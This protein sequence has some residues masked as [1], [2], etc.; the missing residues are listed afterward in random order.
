[1]VYLV[2]NKIFSYIECHFEINKTYCNCFLLLTSDLDNKSNMIIWCDIVSLACP[3]FI[4]I[5]VWNYG[6][7]LLIVSSLMIIIISKVYDVCIKCQCL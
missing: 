5:L 2:H 7:P 3:R 1:M 4:A 6:C